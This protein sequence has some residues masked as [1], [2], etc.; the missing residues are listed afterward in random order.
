MFYIDAL[1]LINLAIENSILVEKDGG[2]FVYREKSAN[3]E[4]GWYLDDKDIIIREVM[5]SKEA[6][7][8]LISTLKEKDVEFV[9]IDKR[10]FNKINDIFLKDID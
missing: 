6:Q 10:L 1:N 3:N 4:E 2:I 8:I 5:Q 7:D 9:E